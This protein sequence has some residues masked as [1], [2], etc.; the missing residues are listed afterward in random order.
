MRRAASS[1]APSRSPG[2][3]DCRQSP[4]GSRSRYR[5]DSD[6][7]LPWLGTLPFEDGNEAAGSRVVRPR[8][9][10]RLRVEFENTDEPD[11]LRFRS[12]L[13]RIDDRTVVVRAE[14]WWEAW[15]QF[16]F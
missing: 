13:E 7:A 2:L 14:T 15:Q 11:K 12:G 10:V 5:H 9:P 16:Y 3:A 1:A 6:L 4:A 8:E